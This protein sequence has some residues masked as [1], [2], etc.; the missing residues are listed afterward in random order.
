[1]CKMDLSLHCTLL[2][3]CVHDMQ[4]KSILAKT[5]EPELPRKSK[6][7]VIF[8]I[9]KSKRRDNV[10]TIEVNTSDDSAECQ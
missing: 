5:N 2:G 4:L 10:N 6:C 3:A 7:F 8:F 1:V 9:Y